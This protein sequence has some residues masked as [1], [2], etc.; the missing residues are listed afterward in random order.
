MIDDCL[1]KWGIENVFT[2]TV[3]NATTNDVAVSI[4]TRRVNGWGGSV[5]NGDYM[6]VRCCAHILN[7]IVSDGLKE[8][9][10]S[11]LSIRATVRYIRLSSARVECVCSKR[12]N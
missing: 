1:H 4:L 9:H 6:H 3:D 5:L 11:I 8:L 7:L 2:I 12:K 10:Q